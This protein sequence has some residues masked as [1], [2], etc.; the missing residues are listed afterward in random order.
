MMRCISI[1]PPQY[2]SSWHTPL[3]VRHS[4]AVPILANL[5]NKCIL[6]YKDDCFRRYYPEST[7]P[8]LNKLIKNLCKLKK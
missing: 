2:A 1:Y 4:N 8:N 5:S 6:D 3:T 7:K